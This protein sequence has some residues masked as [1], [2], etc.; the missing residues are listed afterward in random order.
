[1]DAGS[2]R[3][4]SSFEY[5][6]YNDPYGSGTI[7]RGGFRY[8]DEKYSAQIPDNAEVASA[9]SDRMQ[10]WDAKRYDRACQIAGGYEQIWAYKLPSLGEKKLLEFAAVA[11]NL[12]DKEVL[13]ARVTHHFNVTTG[14]SCP[15]VEAIYLDGG[16]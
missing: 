14:Y 11:L 7:I 5:E 4:F 13:S 1:M 12:E 6:D 10:T 16:E 2:K 9:Y 8:G 15:T 3:I